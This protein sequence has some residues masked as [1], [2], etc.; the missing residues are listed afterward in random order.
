MI[1]IISEDYGSITFDILPEPGIDDMVRI[2]K[3][4]MIWMGFAMH[5]TDS[6]FDEELRELGE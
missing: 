2:F 1:N 5:T 6:I 4:I 3:A